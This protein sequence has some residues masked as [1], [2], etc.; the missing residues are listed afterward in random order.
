MCTHL[1]T[2]LPYLI[3]NVIFSIFLIKAVV[4]TDNFSE[5]EQYSGTCT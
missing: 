3:F 1:K 5:Y 4:E 2:E